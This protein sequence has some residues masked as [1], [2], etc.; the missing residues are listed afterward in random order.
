MPSKEKVNN[1]LDWC[2]RK[3]NPIISSQLFYCF[4]QFC[5]SIFDDMAFIKNTVVKFK[6]KQ[7]MLASFTTCQE[8]YKESLRQKDTDSFWIWHCF[9]LKNFN[10][11]L[12][13]SM[14]FL[15]TSYE[16]TM[17]LCL[18]TW[19]C[20][21]HLKISK[22]RKWGICQV[23]NIL[24]KGKAQM[25]LYKVISICLPNPVETNRTSY[26]WGRTVM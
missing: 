11:Y 18:F 20:N 7:K 17:R 1:Y 5:F 6:N 16:A 12:K 24:S 25:L 14:S 3:N 26:A 4:W 21:L 23:C 19:C 8:Q 15:T 10:S 22:I 2:S 9:P 13:K